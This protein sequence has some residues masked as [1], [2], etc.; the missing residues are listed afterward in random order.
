[1]NCVPPE[2]KLEFFED[3]PSDG[4]DGLPDDGVYCHRSFRL[5]VFMGSSPI[6]ALTLQP[7]CERSSRMGRR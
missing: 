5:E 4:V 1:M 6:A 3:G 2:K 7:V